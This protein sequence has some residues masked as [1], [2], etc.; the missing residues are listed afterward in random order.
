MQRFACEI[1]TGVLGQGSVRAAVMA[2]D[3][4][5][6]RGALRLVA[7]AVRMDRRTSLSAPG[8]LPPARS[9]A[10]R[11]GGE[12]L[13]TPLLFRPNFEPCIRTNVLPKRGSA[14]SLAIS[15]GYLSS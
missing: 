11:Q 3:G 4:I 5:R 6:S 2:H 15:S 14:A 10:T 8:R 9:V 1:T 12:A 13:T 7:E